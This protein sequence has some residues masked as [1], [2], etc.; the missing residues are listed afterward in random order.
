VN[1]KV[2]LEIARH[3]VEYLKT[4]YHTEV[5]HISILSPEYSIA[6]LIQYLSEAS[7]FVEEEEEALT[8]EVLSDVLDPTKIRGHATHGIRAVF[9]KYSSQSKVFLFTSFYIR[10]APPTEF[11][12]VLV[13]FWLEGF[14]RAGFRIKVIEEDGKVVYDSGE[15]KLPLAQGKLVVGVGRREIVE[16]ALKIISRF[17]YPGAETYALCDS[18]LE[19]ALSTKEEIAEGKEFFFYPRLRTREYASSKEFYATQN[20]LIEASIQRKNSGA[21]V[22]II[23]RYI[24]PVLIN[25][26]KKTIISLQGTQLKFPTYMFI[27]DRR[28]RWSVCHLLEVESKFSW[29]NAVHAWGWERQEGATVYAGL[30]DLTPIGALAVSVPDYKN[31]LILR[32]WHIAVEKIYPVEE[33]ANT[34]TESFRCAIKEA[35]IYAKSKGVHVDERAL[36][37]AGR[38]VMQALLNTFKDER[39]RPKIRKLYSFQ[40]ESLVNGLKSLIADEH[41]VFVLQARTA[42]GKTLAFLLPVLI[43]V[44][45]LK[46]LLKEKAK[47]GVKALLFYPTTALQNDQASIIFSLLWHINMQ[48]LE[49]KAPILTMGML[50]GHTPRREVKENT[51]PKEVELRLKC[52]LCGSRLVISWQQKKTN[53]YL[54]TIKCSNGSCRINIPHSSEHILLQNMVKASR[55]AIYSYPPDILI[56]NPDIINTRLMLGAR[57][58]PAA[59]TILGKPA[60]VCELCGKVYDKR[61]KPRKCKVCNHTGFYRI[62][63]EYPRIIV[64]DEAHL[65]R[66]AF[67]A[68]VAHVLT[69]IEQ[70]LR[71]LHALNENWRPIYFV[72]SATLNNPKNR[73]EELTAS[74]KIAIIPARLIEKEEP[75]LR[76][77]VFVMPKQYSPEATTSRIIET[78]YAEAHALHKDYKKKYNLELQRLKNILYNRLPATLVFVN[79]ISEANEL[80]SYIRNYVPGVESNG[81]TT[82]WGR[83]RAIVEDMFSRG[84]INII[85]ATSGLEVG[86]DFDRVDFGIIYGMP[87]YISDYTQRI[88]RIGR[89]HHSIIFNIFM[90]DK[91]IDHFYYRNWRLLSDG[92]LRDIHMRSEAYRINRENIEAVRRAGQRIVLDLIS[93]TQDM[94][95]LLELSILSEGGRY[96][97]EIL[98]ILDGIERS[99]ASYVPKALMIT[100]S[101]IL[102]IAINEAK[103]LIKD[104]K[105]RLN[106]YGKLGR[107]IKEGLKPTLRQLRS[108]RTIE[109]EVVYSF[110]PLGVE[111]S[112]NM[113]YA[114][115]HSLPGQVISYKGAFYSIDSYEGDTLYIPEER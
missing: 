45:Y 110:N 3:I 73:A 98:S 14:N 6:S 25:R 76:V 31:A 108:L 63:P 26:T 58:D 18:K 107:A 93:A 22:S 28:D 67:G 60:Y 71:T 102:N 51:T 4:R 41:K 42:G 70:V 74:D 72:S 50:H 79:R 40:E 97:R 48:L 52:P 59:L 112:R 87:F 54:E 62:E 80:L 20:F 84:D 69:R 109:P 111:R 19:E 17:L 78:I 24:A 46:L 83:D 1:S 106:V 115:R 86:V 114:F 99:L 61:S 105:E 43:Y 21:E 34:L 77:H 13:E 23:L 104:I 33:S 68:Q 103:N 37:E 16:E 66:G 11:R 89:R 101:S 44:V 57:E 15:K 96:S 7:T 30:H 113:M 81:H 88:G 9:K 8:G 95:R 36:E 5:P 55:E 27:E 94:D 91:P 38:I 10:T 65:L 35:R 47:P 29:N 53:V 2:Y 39:G 56:A 32:D 64:V 90:P 82:D 85:V 49:K 100:K 92:R 75:T 12:N